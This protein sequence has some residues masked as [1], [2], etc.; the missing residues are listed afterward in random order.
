MLCSYHRTTTHSDA[1]CR[2]R[3]ANRLVGNAHFAQVRPSSVPE[4]CSSWDLPV[5]DDFDEEPCISFSAIEVPPETKPAKAQ[6]EE[7]KVTRTFGPAPT[8]ATEGLSRLFPLGDRQLRKHRTSATCSGW[9]T[10]KSLSRRLPWLCRQSS[11][12]LRT[13]SIANSSPL[14]WTA[15]RQTTL[16]TM[17][18]SATSSAVCGTAFILLCH[19]RFSWPGELC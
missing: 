9:R 12:H 3:P 4:I 16:S 10:T 7:E 8:A 18:L 11:L 13:T 17:A 19:A 6:V 5:R 2:A 15:E 14:W 1:D